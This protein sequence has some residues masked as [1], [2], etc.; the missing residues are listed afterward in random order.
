ML[1]LGLH[2]SVV[3]FKPGVGVIFEP[4]GFCDSINK[5]SECKRSFIVCI[6]FTFPKYCERNAESNAVLAF[7]H[8]PIRAFTPL[9]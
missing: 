4:E 6:K 3:P 1:H 2:L 7:F 8:S 5:G 9:A